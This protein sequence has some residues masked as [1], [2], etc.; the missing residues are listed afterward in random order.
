MLKDKRIHTGDDLK[1]ALSLLSDCSLD[2]VIKLPNGGEWNIGEVR[3][4]KDADGVLIIG[5]FPADN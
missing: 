1:R 5:I 3:Q 2:V 4:C